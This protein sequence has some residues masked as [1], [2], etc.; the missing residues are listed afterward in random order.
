VKDLVEK[1][2]PNWNVETSGGHSESTY[3]AHHENLLKR[4]VDLEHDN[5][6]RKVTDVLRQMI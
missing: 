1:K 3:A 4:Q 5:F 6:K 2:W